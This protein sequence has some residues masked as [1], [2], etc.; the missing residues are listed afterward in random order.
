MTEF[1]RGWRR[2][3]GCVTLVFTLVC[4]IGL[5]RSQTIED[6]F[7]P[8]AELISIK[9]RLQVE[10]PHS[11]PRIPLPSEKGLQ[12]QGSQVPYDPMNGRHVIWRRDWGD[13]HVGSALTLTGKSEPFECY[14]CAFPYWVVIAPLAVTSAY[15]LLSKPRKSVSMKSSQPAPADGA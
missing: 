8:G 3:A 4:L 2:K 12:F 9:G 7:G 15:L 10:I 14:T 13:F 5:H 6:R 1:F 11:Y